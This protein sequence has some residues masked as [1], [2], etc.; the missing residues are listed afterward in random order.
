MSYFVVIEAV[1]RIVER[2]SAA[3]AFCG[4]DTVL[5]RDVELIFVAVE[6]DTFELCEIDLDALILDGEGCELM[7]E[8]L[9]Y[10]IGEAVAVHRAED[11]ALTGIEALPRGE[12][13]E[14][15]L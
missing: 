7:V 8:G 4:G 9:V 5:Y 2:D 1:V 15:I 13:I 10:R 6:L 14:V 11:V 3:V 12:V